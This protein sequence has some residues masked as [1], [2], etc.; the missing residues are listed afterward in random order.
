MKLKFVD[1]LEFE[2]NVLDAVVTKT[3]S[4]L[5]VK[6]DSEIV[7]LPE[8]K[9]D[10]FKKIEDSIIENIKKKGIKCYRFTRGGGSTV[11]GPGDFPFV[12]TSSLDLDIT[13][14]DIMEFLISYF[15]EKGFSDSA[16]SA[17]DIMVNGKKV[18]GI[19]SEDYPRFGMRVTSAIVT[20]TDHT[21]TFR[22]LYN[23]FFN[24]PWY[25]MPYYIP[26]NKDELIESFKNYLEMRGC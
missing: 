21:E 22:E 24:E 1:N 12:L 25:K 17:N 19:V 5:I 11:M 26:L 8:W 3:N 15:K 23:Q 9:C 6:T 14:K 4:L 18:V 10:D 13:C 7:H 2:E 16:I 20:L